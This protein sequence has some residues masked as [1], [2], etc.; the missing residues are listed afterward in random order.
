MQYLESI[1]RSQYQSNAVLLNFLIF[2]HPFDYLPNFIHSCTKSIQSN[3][4]YQRSAVMR[5][6]Q[7]ITSESHLVNDRVAPEHDPLVLQTEDKSIPPM[8]LN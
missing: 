3:T 5:K 6:V 1:T 8:P 2:V 4:R 7:I